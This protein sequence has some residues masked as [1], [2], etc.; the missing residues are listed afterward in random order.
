MAQLREPEVRNFIRIVTSL[1]D[2][3]ET[4]EEVYRDFTLKADVPDLY[5]IDLL[6]PY[7]EPDPVSLKQQQNAEIH[8][9]SNYYW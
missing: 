8:N 4:H 6:D 5:W 2:I 7:S 3:L 9:F 1:L